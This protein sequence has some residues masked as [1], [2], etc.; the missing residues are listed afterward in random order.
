MSAT[1]PGPTQAQPHWSCSQGRGK[2]S[3]LTSVPTPP[4]AALKLLL[5]GQ[6]R[7]VGTATREGGDTTPPLP[8]PLHCT[9]KGMNGAFPMS[10]PRGPRVSFV[11]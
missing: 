9:C 5:Q 11:V 8:S 7:G 4:P 2:I 1:L 3:A 6:E 10:P